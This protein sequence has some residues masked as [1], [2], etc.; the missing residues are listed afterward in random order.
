LAALASAQSSEFGF[1]NHAGGLALVASG[2][3][4]LR[5]QGY[6]LYRFSRPA[7]KPGGSSSTAEPARAVVSAP[8]P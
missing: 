8:L 2:F 7:A 3:A 1:S 4:R 6:P 5:E